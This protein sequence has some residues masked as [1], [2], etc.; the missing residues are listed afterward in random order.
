MRRLIP[1]LAAA[2]GLLLLTGCTRGYDLSIGGSPSAPQFTFSGF[3]SVFGEGPA[4]A[5]NDIVVTAEEEGPAWLITR[6]SACA[7]TPPMRFGAVP[8]GWTQRVAPKPLREGVVY[9]V[10]GSG[11]GFFGGRTFKILRGKIVSRE[12]TGDAPINEVR[13]LH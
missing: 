11:C 1:A 12:G 4:P 6:G 7:P 9:V 2:A 5:L 8:P 3:K 13:D 10:S